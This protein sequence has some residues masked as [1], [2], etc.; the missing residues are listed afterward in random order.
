MTVLSQHIYQHTWVT[1]VHIHHPAEGSVMCTLLPAV[2][3][4]EVLEAGGQMLALGGHREFQFKK[5]PHLSCTRQHPAPL[6]IS[7]CKTFICIAWWARRAGKRDGSSWQLAHLP[8][9]FV[10]QTP[11]QSLL[12]LSPA[13]DAQTF[14][15]NTATQR[16]LYYL[17]Y[18]IQ[19]WIVCKLSPCKTAHAV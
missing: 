1:I 6:A 12:Y 7:P 10:R 16:T 11:V 8:N 18:I 13:L 5:P 3:G 19:N 14:P 4:M 9:P 17:Q 15:S 2:D